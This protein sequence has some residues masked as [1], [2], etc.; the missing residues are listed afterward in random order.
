MQTKS[1]ITILS[2]S[3]FII[4]SLI[5]PVFCFEIVS[6][7]YSIDSYHIGIAGQEPTN[8]QYNSRF[9]STYQQGSNKNAENSNY[10]SNIGWFSLPSTSY[11]GDGTCDAGNGETC[12]T[13]SSDCG[14][15]ISGGGGGGG[16]CSYDWVCSD[17]YPQ[18]CLQEGI[19]NRV[20]V[21]RGTCS[22]TTGFPNQT[23]TCI[24]SIPPGPAD[25]L[26]DLFA[27]IPL[28]YKWINPEDI[29]GID[30]ELIN[31]GNTST[32][33]VFF[34]Y[35]IIDENSTLITEMQETRAVSEGDKFRVAIVIPSETKYG[36]YRFYAQI[37]YDSDKIAIAEDS[38][39]I[40]KSKIAKFIWIVLLCLIM[41]LIAIII[42]LLIRQLKKHKKEDLKKLISHIK[43]EIN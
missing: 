7:N 43:R 3:I 29:I 15:C 22:G 27:K 39:E 11:C 40:V 5:Q 41:F 28:R 8:S 25:P 42:I 1:K 33:D 13:C 23:R 9:T 31:L 17:W 2:I 30:I 26:F 4:L 21:N 10:T 12:S 20:C 6:D 34:K 37:N 35:W 18:P 16:G 24:P 38:F 14:S 32:I 19:Q 36:K